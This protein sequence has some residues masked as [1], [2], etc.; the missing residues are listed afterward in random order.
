MRI[1]SYDYITGNVIERSAAELNFGDVIQGQHTVKPILIRA[2]FDAETI[3]PTNLTIF[4]S[5]KQGWNNT[6]LGYFIG[7]DFTSALE[8]GLLP[9]HFESSPV[10][11]PLNDRT[12]H[13]IWLDADIPIDQTGAAQINFHFDYN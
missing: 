1:E 2:F 10:A 7:S 3:V 8:S 12:S 6:E 5:D 9:F 13:Y 4:P 11:V